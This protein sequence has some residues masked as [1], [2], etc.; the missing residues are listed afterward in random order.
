MQMVKTK[1]ASR[2]GEKGVAG[3]S[4]SSLEWDC[5]SSL[6]V[7]A[8]LEPE[9]SKDRFDGSITSI[10]VINEERKQTGAR[11]NA[12][13]KSAAEV[14]MQME[15]FLFTDLALPLLCFGR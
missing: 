13:E 1:I 2:T 9:L 8:L 15:L 10:I 4:W 3:T 12:R 14:G 6:S 7:G 11:G 5:F